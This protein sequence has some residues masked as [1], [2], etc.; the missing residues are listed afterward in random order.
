MMVHYAMNVNLPIIY[1]MMGHVRVVLKVD[2]DVHI[3]LIIQYVYHVH[4]A[5]TSIKMINV[6][7]VQ[8]LMD[9]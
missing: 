3:A 2:M 4:L 6:S 1:L 5:I 9:V 8:L 7:Y